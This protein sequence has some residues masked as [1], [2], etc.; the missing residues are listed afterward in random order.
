MRERVCEHNTRYFSCTSLAKLY[1]TVC[2]WLLLEPYSAFTL[3]I[4]LRCSLISYRRDSIPHRFCF[5]ISKRTC[6]FCCGGST[7]PIKASGRHLQ[8]CE[9]QVLLWHAA[10]CLSAYCPPHCTSG[11]PWASFTTEISG[12]PFSFFIHPRGRDG[13][14][15]SRFAIE[16]NSS[17]R[18]RG[19]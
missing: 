11:P 10:S 13:L 4:D 16:F 12:W 8:L 15:S 7:L 5:K 14:L 9:V 17:V 2:L 1:K 6:W 19:I 18:Q 3:K